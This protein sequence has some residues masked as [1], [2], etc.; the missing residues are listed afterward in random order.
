KVT[1]IDYHDYDLNQIVRKSFEEFCAEK[2]F[3]IESGKY[4]ISDNIYRVEL[5]TTDELSVLDDFDGLLAITT[6]PEYE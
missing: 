1:L 5:A 6:M 2:N 3:A 4:S